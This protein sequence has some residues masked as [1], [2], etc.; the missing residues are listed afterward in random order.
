M[1]TFYFTLSPAWLG[2]WI[3]TVFLVA[4]QFVFMAIFKDGGK[5]AVDT[6]WYGP[7]EWHYANTTFVLQVAMIVLSV[8]LPFKWG[9]AWFVVGTIIYVVSTIMFVWSFFSYG[10]APKGETIRN[11]VYRYSRNPMYFFYLTGMVGVVVACASAYLLLLLVPYAVATH[12]VILGEERYCA[13]TYGD[14]YLDYKAATPRY[15]L[16]F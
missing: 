14:S 2:G 3:P 6:S 11:G 15:F 5:R 12:G 16:F 9:T 10:R 8:F 4:I 1:N 7:S 13:K